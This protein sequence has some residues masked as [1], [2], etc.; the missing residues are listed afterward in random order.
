MA[1]IAEAAERDGTKRISVIAQEVMGR[2]TGVVGPGQGARTD[3]K[4]SD[5]VKKLSEQGGNSVDYLAARIKRD[6]PDIAEAVERG[7]EPTRAALKR[8]IGAARSGGLSRARYGFGSRAHTAHRICRPLG[9]LEN[10]G[11]RGDDGF[12]HCVR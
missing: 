2:S 3:L 10:I 5:S 11:E 7:E 12:C 6:R 8:E 9:R 1:V 4:P